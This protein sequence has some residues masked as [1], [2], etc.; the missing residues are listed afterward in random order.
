MLHEKLLKIFVGKVDAHLLKATED[1][2]IST[3]S[4]SII[5][6]TTLVNSIINVLM[7]LQHQ[8]N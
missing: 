3:H 5:S 2:Q 1:N 7:I 6:T 8:T 4:L